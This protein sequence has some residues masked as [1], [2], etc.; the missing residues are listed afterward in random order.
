MKKWHFMVAAMAIAVVAALVVWFGRPVL[1]HEGREVGGYEI[2][3][4]WQVEPAMP[5]STTA[6]KCSFIRMV[7]RERMKNPWLV[8]R[9]R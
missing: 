7:R 2:A 8:P 5:G 3:F 1:A 6:L 4:G 9:R